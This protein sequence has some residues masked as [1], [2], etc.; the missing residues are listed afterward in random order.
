MFSILSVFGAQKTVPELVKLL[1]KLILDSNE[2]LTW[3]RL[4]L[5][6]FTIYCLKKSRQIVHMSKLINFG[7]FRTRNV[8]LVQ[9]K[10]HAGRNQIFLT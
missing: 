4:F 2:S 7:I 8:T 3:C 10:L 9:K 5:Y 6:Y 1:R